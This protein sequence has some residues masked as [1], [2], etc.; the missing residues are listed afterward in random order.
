[1][2]KLTYALAAAATLAIGAP[3]IPNAAGVGFYVGYAELTAEGQR[4]NS[5]VLVDG[6]GRLISKYRKVHLPGSVEPRAGQKYQ[7]LE[8]RCRKPAQ[9]DTKACR[10][11]R[12]RQER[13]REE[14]EEQG[15]SH[16]DPGQGGAGREGQRDGRCEGNG[17]LHGWSPARE[18]MLAPVLILCKKCAEAG[19]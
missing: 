5:A 14:A 16:H 8:K 12:R 11:Y 18:G 7:Q 9:R 3:T 17:S 6:R 4:F 19:G 10:D 15:S 13:K 1:M 2:R